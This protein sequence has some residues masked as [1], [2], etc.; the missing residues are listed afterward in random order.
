[1]PA[2]VPVLASTLVTPASK[3]PF[4][5]LSG[6]ADSNNVLAAPE[7]PPSVALSRIVRPTVWKVVPVAATVAWR[8]AE[9]NSGPTTRCAAPALTTFIRRQ[10]RRRRKQSPRPRP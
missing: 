1:M 9:P 2:A 5:V 10:S 3:P 6:A 8:M 7:R 4:Q